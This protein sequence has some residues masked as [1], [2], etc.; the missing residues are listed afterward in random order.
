MTGKIFGRWGRGGEG[1]GGG[2][3]DLDGVVV[4]FSSPSSVTSTILGLDRHGWTGGLLD[5]FAEEA[6]FPD[7]PTEEGPGMIARG[8]GRLG[9]RGALGG[10]ADDLV[11]VEKNNIPLLP[12]IRDDSSTV[13]PLDFVEEIATNMICKKKCVVRIQW[14]SNMLY[15]ALHPPPHFQERWLKVVINIPNPLF[16]L[17]TFFSLSPFMSAGNPDLENI[18]LSAYAL[19]QMSE[20]RNPPPK[21]QTTEP[22]PV[23][24]P[25]P[26]APIPP[27]QLQYFPPTSSQ[28]VTIVTG[29][30]V[31]LGTPGWEYFYKTEELSENGP[32]LKCGKQKKYVCIAFHFLS[33]PLLFISFSLLFLSLL[34]PYPRHVLLIPKYFSKRFHAHAM[35]AKDHTWP[36]RTQSLATVVSSVELI[37]FFRQKIHKNEAPRPRNPGGNIWYRAIVNQA[38]GVLFAEQVWSF[39][40]VRAKR[41]RQC[42]SQKQNTQT[43]VLFL[44]GTRDGNG[45]GRIG[46]CRL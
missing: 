36:V 20:S 3:M 32:S 35:I 17:D 37:A 25:P 22:F 28:E 9:V 16:V 15:F 5:F 30:Q 43:N 27:V 7:F 26:P 42:V 33:C 45:G 6:L 21:E 40:C 29:I 10:I 46:N 44:L 13:F 23:E 12:T 24:M 34:P 11:E 1:E 41:C 38:L 39:F 8:K 31:N 19:L 18:L 14:F 2:V 4:V